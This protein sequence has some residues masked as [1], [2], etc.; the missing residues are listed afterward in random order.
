MNM[1]SVRTQ[2]QI[3]KNFIFAATKKALRRNL[4]C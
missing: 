2:Q 3:E 1:K 4:N